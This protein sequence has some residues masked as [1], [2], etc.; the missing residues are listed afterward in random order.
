MAVF[1]SPIVRLLLFLFH[2]AAKLMIDSL[3]YKE[4]KQIKQEVADTSS[5]SIM[6]MVQLS[7]GK[8][9]SKEELEIF[10]S[11]FK[12]GK[13]TVK[14]IMHPRL[15]I[16]AIPHSCNFSQVLKKMKNAEYSRMP[17]YENNID[18]IIEMIYIKDF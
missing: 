7:I 15:D 8:D 12:F 4:E 10:K 14:Q 6:N 2:Q 5:E 11:I 18:N 17:I 13:I 9:I 1:S 16:D 3:A